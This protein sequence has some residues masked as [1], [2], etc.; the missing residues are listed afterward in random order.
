MDASAASTFGL[1]GFA[2]SLTVV[3]EPGVTRDEITKAFFGRQGVASVQGASALTE[4]LR[5]RI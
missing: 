4:S 5:E 1:S 2:N 3:P